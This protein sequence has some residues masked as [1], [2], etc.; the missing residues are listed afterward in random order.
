[1]TIWSNPQDLHYVGLIYFDHLVKSIILT[2]WSN[3]Q[4]PHYVGLNGIEL[5]DGAGAPVQVACAQYLTSI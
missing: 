4:D 3:P 1:L 2:I 5:H